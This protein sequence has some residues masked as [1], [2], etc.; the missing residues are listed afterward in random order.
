MWKVELEGQK[1]EMTHKIGGKDNWYT[2]GAKYWENVPA[3]VDGVLGGL[4]H[5][6]KQD[7]LDSK[8]F[9]EKMKEKNIIKSWNRALDCGAGIGR[10]SQHLL[11][12]FFDEVD[13][14]EQNP[15]YIEQARINIS[16]TNLQ[17]KIEYYVAGLQDFAYEKKYDVI[18]VQWVIG[19]LTDKDFCEFLNRSKASLSENVIIL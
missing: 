5:L 2:Y 12:H 16:E 15:A 11:C 17:N 9:L 1:S 18:W 4:G 6:D 13:Q 19:H 10:I 3:T 7:I 8:K 14:V